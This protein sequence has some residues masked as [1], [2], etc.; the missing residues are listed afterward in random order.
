M[1]M[2]NRTFISSDGRKI[3]CYFFVPEGK[4]KAILQIVHG[5]GEHAGKYIEF[6]TYLTKQGFLVCAEDHRGFGR[7]SLSKEQIGHISDKDGHSLIISDML[8]LMEHTKTEYRDV[9]YFLFGHS[10][11]SFLTRSFL[12]K[13]PDSVQGAIICG[14]KGKN[15]FIEKLGGAFVTIQKYIFRGRAKAKLIHKL[16]IGGYSNKYFKDEKCSLSWLTSDSDEWKRMKEDEYSSNNPASI[17]TYFQLFSIFEYIEKKE[18]VLKMSKNTP[19]FL[20]SGKNDPVGNFGEGVK[21]VY[22]FYK[23]LGFKSVDIKIYENGRHE[24]LKDKM[25]F[26]VMDD[27]YAWINNIIK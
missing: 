15:G 1:E 16:S 10:M 17:E 9:P 19:I 6:A 27:I 13:Y 24:I 8:M 21:W 20:I 14:T 7:S 18:N 5:L 23:S 22:E 4:P 11:G 12:I 3:Y 2:K 26:E 25:R